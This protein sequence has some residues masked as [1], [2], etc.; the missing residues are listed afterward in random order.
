MLEGKRFAAAIAALGFSVAVFAQ[1]N[2]PA[3]RHLYVGFGG[4]QAHWRPG[5]SGSVPDCHDTNVS[6]HVFAGYQLNHIFAGEVA[7]TNY[8]KAD[9]TNF[10]VLGRG[11]EASVVGG[12]PVFG[13]ISAIGRLGA[14]RGV[15]KGGGQIA[16]RTE[17]NYGFTY[18]VG[19]QMD[20]TPSLAARLE[21]QAFPG[22]GGST[23][24]KS[25]VNITSVSA[26]W[27]FR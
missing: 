2:A 12:W 16:N 23:I 14:Y 13:S 25:D 26:L 1:G 18:G 22:V 11:W 6:V 7:F 20:F 9:G 5:C 19:A 10:E 21:W 8:G 17:S 15:V 24:P 3:Q 4:G 27:R